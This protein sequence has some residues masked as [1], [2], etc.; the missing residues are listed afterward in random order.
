MVSANTESHRTAFLVSVDL[1]HGT[2]TGISAADR[3]ATI[4]ALADPLLSPADLARPGHV[5][6]LRARAGGVHERAGHTEAAV[7]LCRMAGLSGAALLCEIVTADRRDMMRRPELD[8]F[9]IRHGIPMITIAD[10]VRST[11]AAR[12]VH[13]LRIRRTG[14][15]TIPSELGT[16]RAISYRS[17]TDSTEHLALA[18]GDLDGK[19]D[20][21][22]RLHSE[23][24]TGDLMGSLRCDCGAQ[25]RMAM[26]AIVAEGQGV[27]VY[28]R[29]HEGRGIGLGHKLQA[30]QLQQTRGLD[31][32]EANIRLGLPV[33]D[34]DYGAGARI[35][36]DLGIASARLMTN[37]PKKCQ[38]LTEHGMT[39]TDRIALEAVPNRHNVGYL[40]AKRDRLGHLL[41]SFA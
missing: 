28:L 9:A 29:G 33:D 7:Q 15:A 20:V 34:R 38:A 32:V 22:V 3:A 39:V 23:C 40:T 2:T 21:L 4:R 35:L 14:E 36:K 41:R 25:L 6:P 26:N 18:M 31:T 8:D 30:Y 17:A 19:G 24:L 11:P 10:L 1:K 16:F 13:D 5:M 37:N 27:I 12:V